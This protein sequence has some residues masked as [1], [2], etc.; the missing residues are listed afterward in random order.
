MRDLQSVPNTE[1]A[2]PDYPK[3]RIRDKAGAV[4]GTT[5]TEGFLGDISQFFQKLIIDAGISENGLP[6]NVSNGYQLIT[7]LKDMINKNTGFRNSNSTLVNGTMTTTGKDIVSIIPHAT[8]GTAQL[9][10]TVTFRLAHQASSNT[11][12]A[13]ELMV[14]GVLAQAVNQTVFTDGRGEMISL[15][16]VTPYTANTVVAL[17]GRMST[18]TTTITVPNIVCDAL[19][20]T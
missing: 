13:F 9:K 18:S 17:Q 1:G 10:T 12:I 6:D 2:T 7:A 5:L 16:F 14:D 8:K 15:T 3:G 20:T 19:E 11:L 4:A